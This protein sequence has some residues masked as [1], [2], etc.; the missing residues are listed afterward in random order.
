[1]AAHDE[2]RAASSG[3]RAFEQKR[4][5]PVTLFEPERSV[6][7]SKPAAEFKQTSARPQSSEPDLTE[8]QAADRQ[9]PPQQANVHASHSLLP[10][11]GLSPLQQNPQLS[12]CAEPAPHRCP[13]HQQASGRTPRAGQAADERLLLQRAPH[14][15]RTE[16]AAA[17]DWDASPRHDLAPALG[18]QLPRSFFEQPAQALSPALLG[19]RLVHKHGGQRVSGIIVEAEAY[20]I[21]GAEDLACHAARNKGRPT[22]RTEVNSNLK[23]CVLLCAFAANR[24]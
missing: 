1:M 8:G 5:R 21:A 13:P 10:L 12:E 18:T 19:K 14:A 20:G 22:P 23:S 9:S 4:A 2:V 24:V 11:D 16:P 7:Q 15:S 3:H 6:K 17:L